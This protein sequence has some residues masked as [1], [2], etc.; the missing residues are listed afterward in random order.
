MSF[1]LEFSIEANVGY[2]I[3]K[4]IGLSGPSMVKVVNHFQVESLDVIGRVLNNTY[5]ELSIVDEK[6]Y[7]VS[8]YSSMLND[9][10]DEANMAATRGVK[11]FTLS[12]AD[13]NLSVEIKYYEEAVQ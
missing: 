5:G 6:Q 2:A 13:D 3:R 1:I 11:R 12:K 4:S 10:K 8:K 9:C 7:T